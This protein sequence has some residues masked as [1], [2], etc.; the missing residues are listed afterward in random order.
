MHAVILAGGKGTRLAPYTTVFPKPLVPI[1]DMP[2]LEIVV[3]Q[4]HYFGVRHI[5]MA[6][7][8]LAELIMAYFGDGSRFDV[9]I[10]YS[11]EDRPLGTAG[12]LALIPGLNETFLVLNGDLLT[13]LN[14]GDLINYHNEK[15]PV[16][17]V[18]TYKRQLQIDF[19][20]LKVDGASNIVD[21][22][23][24]PKYTHWVS[25][26]VYVFEPEALS[27]LDTG[28]YF[29]LPEFILRLLSNK[30][31]VGAYP[32]DGYWLDIGR[33]GDYERAVEQF[34]Q[35]RAQLLHEKV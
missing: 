6:V 34:A 1:G 19:G 14:F 16:A 12:P 9:E 31:S 13:T 18:A 33:P 15:S 24:K 25:M 10:Q 8:Y 5:T 23:E 28:Q 11:R 20:I 32:F 35:F 2:I 3:R 26:G 22:L 27:F 7:G 21:Y 4:L 30:K 17:T 29:D